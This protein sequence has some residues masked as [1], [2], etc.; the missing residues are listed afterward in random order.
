MAAVVD[1][2]VVAYPEALNKVAQEL[3]TD[4]L[5]LSYFLVYELLPPCSSPPDRHAW[6]GQ[7]SRDETADSRSD[8]PFPSSLL[9]AGAPQLSSAQLSSAQLS[10][11]QLGSAQLSSAQLSSAQLSSAQLSSQSLLRIAS[12]CLGGAGS[13]KPTRP[14]RRGDA[15]E[16]AREPEQ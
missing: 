16:A 9:P 13:G 6:Q 12:Q 10:S 11:A 14:P 5:P 1:M 2:L 3:S 7:W 4:R 8:L 15:R